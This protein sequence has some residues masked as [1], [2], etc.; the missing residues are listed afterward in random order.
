MQP[1]KI[2]QEAKEMI[3]LYIDKGAEAMAHVVIELIAK[4]NTAPYTVEELMKIYRQ[5]FYQN[6]LT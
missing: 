1:D 3:M 4:E 5:K 2:S 6:N